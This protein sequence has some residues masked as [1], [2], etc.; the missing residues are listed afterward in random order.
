[1]KQTI[2][3]IGHS[4][5]ET[6]VFLARLRRHEIEVVADVRSS[7][8]SAYNPQ[9]NKPVIQK[10]LRRSGIDYVYM[11]GELG[12]R[13]EDPACYEGDR[14]SY[15]LL[16][17]TKAFQHGIERVLRGAE[18][19]RIALLCA[20]KDPLDCHRTILVSRRLVERGANVQHILADGEL[21]NHNSTVDRLLV[22]LDLHNGDL[23]RSTAELIE[24]AY[25]I[26]GR[27][28]AY[29]N[30]EESARPWEATI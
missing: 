26:Q 17:Q 29:R 10:D 3:S 28:I 18:S 19:L 27:R 30:P 25:R 4:T 7:P 23:F 2:F 22:K 20:E 11:G 14:V 24:D 8:F 9:F 21:E 13:S 12:P 6:D 5:H 15:E 16:A 1:M